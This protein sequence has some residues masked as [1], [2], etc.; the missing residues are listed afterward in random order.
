MPERNAKRDVVDEYEE[1]VI[2]CLL[3][4]PELYWDIDLSTNDFRSRRLAA[5]Y[6]AICELNEEQQRVDPVTV[7]EAL[8]GEFQWDAMKLLEL[9]DSVASTEVVHTYADKVKEHSV[10]RAVRMATSRLSKSNRVG[11]DL[12]DEAQRELGGLGTR[13]SKAEAYPASVVCGEV[14][15]KMERRRRGEVVEGF[16][17]GVPEFDSYLNILPGGM[18]FLAGRPSMGKSAVAQ[19]IVDEVCVQM[20]VPTLVFTTESHREEYI[21]RMLSRH[22]GVNMK[23][24][25][26]GDRLGWEKSQRVKDARDVIAGAPLYIDDTSQERSDIVRQARR[27][28]SRHGI[29]LLVLDH[30]QEVTDSGMRGS[31]Q[32]VIN[33]TLSGI[34][35]VCR[36][37]PKMYALVLSQLNRNVESREGKRPIIADLRASGKIEEVAD[38]V[39][40]LFRPAHYFPKADA[41]ECD[42]AVAKNRNGPTGVIT[43]GWNPRLGICDGCLASEYSGYAVSGGRNETRS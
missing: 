7:E 34:R 42:F 28:R 14:I 19:W 1:G 3:I 38:F 39:G 29:K 13:A 43:L 40:L 17:L 35:A 36:E 16:Q 22:S 33:S 10:D 21:G 37:D 9:S 2:G 32:E 20:G 6:R 12:L 5:V 25:L 24:I 27:Y 41:N 18:M 30:L 11:Y 26:H 4:R 23:A 8:G 31:D 15:E